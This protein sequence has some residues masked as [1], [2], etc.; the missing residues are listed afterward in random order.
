MKGGAERGP[1]PSPAGEPAARQE[2]G[3][4]TPVQRAEHEANAVALRFALGRGPGGVSP[5][6]LAGEARAQLAG[7]APASPSG[8]GG[9]RVALGAA[10]GY[11]FSGVRLR[12]DPAAAA[13]A[14]A[15]RAHAFAVGPEVS[16]APGRFRPDLPLGRALIAHELVHVAQTGSAPRRARPEDGI[17]PESARMHEAA[18]A[19]AVAPAE[20]LRGI[21]LRMS[22]CPDSSTTAP[23]SQT[24]QPPSGTGGG[25]TPSTTTPGTTT[26]GT[27]TTTAPAGPPTPP[28][29]LPAAFTTHY[30]TIDAAV[31]ALN[32]RL[33]PPTP[34]D[35][36][37]IRAMMAVETVAGTEPRKF[38]PLQV[39]NQGDPA[40][41]VLKSGG[42]HSNLIDPGLA[43]QLKGKKSTPRNEGKWDYGALKESE[44]M[45]AATGIV[46]GVAW[47]A[48]KAANFKE[49]NVE[50]GPEMTHTVQAGDTYPK[51]AKK[52]GT[53]VDT[54]TSLNPGVDPTK[55]Q[56]GKTVL[57]YKAA[58]KEW[59]ISGWKTWEKAA[60]DYNGGGDP[61]YLKKV[62]AKFDEIKKA[63]APPAKP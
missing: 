63:T 20:G 47:L 48:V 57:K 10:L 38:D 4:R 23:P 44:R 28:A 27:A 55:L 42:E 46:A 3:P 53:T 54:L 29:T 60:E 32:Q 34:L 62:K 7:P 36:D 49:V 50:T 35:P 22:D 40:L 26:P 14:E 17:D 39:A 15:D 43:A 59:Q 21:R 45:D 24:S 19:E 11:D 31:A 30:A 33:H 9:V 56:I 61:D 41:G 37:W 1:R 52:L 58:H 51:L 2:G 16:F 18:H 25:P 6:S 12:T 13:A 5:A 8:D